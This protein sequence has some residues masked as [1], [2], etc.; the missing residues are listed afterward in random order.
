MCVCV[1]RWMTSIAWLKWIYI[2]ARD[3][4]VTR[5]FLSWQVFHAPF[6]LGIASLFDQKIFLSKHKRLLFRRNGPPAKALSIL[7]FTIPF[8]VSFSGDQGIVSVRV[9]FYPILCRITDDDLLKNIHTNPIY[10]SIS[11]FHHSVLAIFLKTRNPD[12][13]GIII[14]IATFS[15]TEI[16]CCQTT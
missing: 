11:K 5:A 3:N 6:M 9:H 10:F 16:D 12:R 15:F 7:A 8:P 13:E 14:S 1:W 4:T 2:L